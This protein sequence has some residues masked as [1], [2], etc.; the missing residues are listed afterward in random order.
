MTE[1]FAT[2]LIVTEDTAGPAGVVAGPYSMRGTNVLL[3]R[4]P[5]TVIQRRDPWRSVTHQVPILSRHQLGW[6][7]EVSDAET[8]ELIFDAL[9]DPDRTTDVSGLRT[10]NLGQPGDVRRFDFALDPVEGGHFELRAA[11]LIEAQL[12]M[13]RGRLA[14]WTTQWL[15]R[16]LT[17][18][19][20]EPVATDQSGI[21]FGGS[22]DVQ[23]EF[24][25]IEA[26]IMSGAIAFTRNIEPA[27]YDD[28][29]MATQWTGRHSVDVVGRIVCRLPF[30]DYAEMMVGKLIETGITVSFASGNKER[31]IIL[32]AV[33]MQTTNRAF[34]SQGTYEYS[35]DFVAVREVGQSV[36]V[37]T[38][39][40]I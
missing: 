8:T 2:S 15:G 19:D 29:N 14:T 24:D 35:V 3:T 4:R 26:T 1:N 36:A 17:T 6:E 10:W 37:L 22:L 7:F 11:A 25:D 21:N 28:R 30:G 16:E 12:V 38:S 34:I 9:A 23:I 31:Q 27:Q 13:D 5:I 39:E 40:N 32:P 33:R 20:S 18:D